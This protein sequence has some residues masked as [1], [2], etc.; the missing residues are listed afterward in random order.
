MAKFSNR[1]QD[2]KSHKCKMPG[3]EVYINSIIIII[4]KCMIKYI[5]IIRFMNVKIIKCA[6]GQEEMDILQNIVF[7]K[8]QHFA[9]LINLAAQWIWS[10]SREHWV[11]RRRKNSHTFTISVANS[12][13]RTTKETWRTLT[14]TCK[15]PHRQ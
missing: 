12:Q 4:I 10:F 9:L 14:Q 13:G 2:I 8:V 3:L 1:N 5:K 6:R 15:S 7:F 11:Q